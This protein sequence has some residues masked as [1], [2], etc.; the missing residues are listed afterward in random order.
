VRPLPEWL[1]TVRL[2]PGP[3]GRLPHAPRRLWFISAG[4]LALGAL[5]A[6]ALG[7]VTASSDGRIGDR[8]FVAQANARC[9][10]TEADVIGP[11]SDPKSGDLEAER[12]ETITRAWDQMVVDLAAIDVQPADRGRVE[13]WLAAWGE[14][15]AVSHEYAD[16]LAGGDDRVARKVLARGE[17]PRRTIGRFAYV[18]GMNACVFR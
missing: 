18:N 9:A 11:N 15:T 4:C 5:F 16:A 1:Q 14:W 10:R 12:I 7:Q 17:A 8:H 6:L 13:E 2:S 3:P